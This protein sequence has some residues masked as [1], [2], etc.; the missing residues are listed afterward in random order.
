MTGLG[1]LGFAVAVA[2]AGR[3]SV[4]AFRPLAS[5]IRAGSRGISSTTSLSATQF[6]LT[7]DYIPDVLEKRGPYREGHIGLAKKLIGEGKCVSGGPIGEVAMEV[8]TGAIFV[9][10]DAASAEL[11]VEQDPYVS[12]GIVTGHKIQEWNV[13]VQKED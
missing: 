1:R 3:Q 9:F 13:V 10:N 5:G 2:A 8:P 7:Y 12:A 4:L 11:F 6:V